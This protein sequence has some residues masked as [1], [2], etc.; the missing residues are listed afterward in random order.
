[1]NARSALFDLYGDHLRS[2]GGRAPVAALVRLLAP[3][4]VAAPAVRTAVSRMVKQGWL[5]PV[6]IDGA[7]GYAL[8]PRAVR[9]LDTAADRIYRR[10]V[11]GWDGCWHVVVPWHVLDRAARERL[12]NG[13]RYL[14]YAPL[15]DGTWVAPRPSVELD[16]LLESEGQS[17]ECFI[18]RHDGREGGDEGLVRRAWDLDAIGKAYEAWLAEAQALVAGVDAGGAPERAFAARS[19]L[20]HGWRKFLFTDPWLPRELLPDHWPGDEAAAFFD[21]QAGRLQRAA[22]GFVDSCLSARPNGANL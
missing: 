1:M 15:G 3:L 19:R 6:R 17:A 20:V 2:R 8:T 13:L 4:D 21:S 10:G 5:D 7:P 18:A 11:G 16:A 22:A 14:G 9:R 12:R